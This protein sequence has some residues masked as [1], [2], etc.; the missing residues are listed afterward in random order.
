MK[1]VPVLFA[2][3]VCFQLASAL[4]LTASADDRSRAIGKAIK[5]VPIFDAHVHYKAPAWGPYPPATV[6]E[7]MDKN[8]VAMALVSSTPDAGTIRLW[9]YAPK[10]IVPELRPYH[11]TAGSSNWT[12]TAGML[13]YLKQRLA[14]Y[15]HQGIGEFHIHTLDPTDEP[16]LRA[17]TQMAKARRIP[18]HIHSGARPVALLYRLEPSL[19]VIWAHAG[20][21]EPADVVGRTMAKYPTLYA[22]TSYREGDILGG[23]NGIDP[24]WRDVIERFQDRLMVGTD[25]WVN[26]QWDSYSE[27]IAT[28]RRWLSYFPRSIAEK[29]AYRNAERLF[30]RKISSA[31]IGQR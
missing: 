11:G 7:L 13:D 23:S 19:T 20:M 30:K 22:D 8:G 29:I 1:R 6:I 14:K 28:N 9:Q 31:L 3:I 10:R 18:I 21:S 25:T 27:L 2:V 24:A 16:L 12:K 5:D 26:A 15:P 17:V 4:A